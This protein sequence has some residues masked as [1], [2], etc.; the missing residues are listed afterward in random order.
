M[1][2][3]A[4][5]VSITP[6]KRRTICS[7]G[8]LWFVLAPRPTRVMYRA[9]SR[10]KVQPSALARLCGQ[11]DTAGHPLFLWCTYTSPHKLP[12]ERKE[13]EVRY[14][15]TS[16]NYVFIPSVIQRRFVILSLYCSI[17]TGSK[18]VQWNYWSVTVSP[19]FI[20]M[21]RKRPNRL[22]ASGKSRERKMDRKRWTSHGFSLFVS[23]KASLNWKKRLRKIC[24]RFFCWCSVYLTFIGVALNPTIS[25]SHERL[26]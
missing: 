23:D 10:I 17:P 16:I 9:F 21:W 5:R 15:L 19:R 1:V 24:Y 22:I 6:E 7:G 25:F 4:N 26:K 2:T 20:H 18:I 3:R 12:K 8:T 14:S 11:N 13:Y